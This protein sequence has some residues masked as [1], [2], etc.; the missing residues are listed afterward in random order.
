M[1]KVLR[2]IVFVVGALFVCVAALVTVIAFTQGLGRPIRYEFAPGFTGWVMI[3]YEN[4]SCP[5]LQSKG[6]YI[7]IPISPNGRACTSSSVPRGWRYL[8]HEYVSPEGKRSII[9]HNGSESENLV[10]GGSVAPAQATV[11][12]PRKTFFIGTRD[13]LEKNWATEPDVRDHK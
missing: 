2:I 5:P 10:W 7:V 6:F 13:Q 4:P 9:T 8:R 3:E 12:F 1:R 11:R